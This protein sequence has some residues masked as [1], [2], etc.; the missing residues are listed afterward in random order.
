M[1]NSAPVPHLKICLPPRNT[2]CQ[3]NSHIHH[4]GLVTSGTPYTLSF[5][6]NI[7]HYIQLVVLTAQYPPTRAP[8]LWY[9]LYSDTPSPSTTIYYTKIQLVVLSIH[10]PGFVTSATPYTLSF[11]NNILHYI[12][13]V[14]LSIHQLVHPIHPLLLLQYTIQTYH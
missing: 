8:Y 9:T 5:N 10:H 6:N 13:L 2:N 3:K 12:Q 7:L 14:V 1:L 4:P 11:Y